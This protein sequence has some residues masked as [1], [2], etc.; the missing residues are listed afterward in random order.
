MATT[1]QFI[2]LSSVAVI[3]RGTTM[4]LTCHELSS[5]Y[6]F[7]GAKNY[8]ILYHVASLCHVTTISPRPVNIIMLSLTSYVSQ[9]FHITSV[10]SHMS[11]V[12]MHCLYV[13]ILLSYQ[14]VTIMSHATI[15]SHMSTSCHVLVSCHGAC[16]YYVIISQGRAW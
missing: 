11:G 12:V 15:M 5:V 9:L 4:L 6:H 14:G 7:Y 8:T 13:T 2:S 3:S 16:H 1:Y 10:M